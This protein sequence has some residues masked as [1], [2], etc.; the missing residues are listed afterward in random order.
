MSMSIVTN[1]NSLIAQENLRVNNEF[2]SRTIQRLTSGYRINSSGDDA[3]G[4]AVANKFR[5]D[6]AEL[7]QGIRNA[8]DGISALQ[9]IDGG[10]N[11]I[12]KMLDRLKTLATQS[13]SATFS[14]NRTTL[15][16]EYQALLT[17]INRQ[18][19]NV[20]L[21]VGSYGGR[22]NTNISVYVGGGGDTQAN[23]KVSIDLSGSSNRVD[24]VGLGLSG[25]SIAAG[26]ATEL[27]VSNDLSTGT[28]FLS[29]STS[30]DFTFRIAMKGMPATD[31][32]VTI[33]GDSDGISGNDVV[34]QFNNALASYG[35]SASLSGTTGKLQF[36]GATAFTLRVASQT[37]TNP[38]VSGAGNL[39]NESMYRLSGAATF[40]ALSGAN[41]ETVEFRVGSQSVSVTLNA[42][43][44]NTIQNALN[45]LNGAINGLGIYAVKNAAGT[46]VEF[47]SAANFQ[48]KLDA[49]ATEGVFAAMTDVT[50][51][52][53]APTTPSAGGGVTS[54]AE[55]AIARITTA[56]ANLGL[57]QGKVGTAQNKLQYSIQ[58]AQSQVASFS[59]AESRIRDADVAAEAANLTKAQVMQ[60][61][62]LAAMAQANSAPQS[63]LALLRG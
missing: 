53:D 2:Q 58:L 36:S 44:G 20:G 57:V 39:T 56:V 24:A 59:A 9:I 54:A 31:I 45:T 50:T 14:G 49:H 47:Q 18:A 17:E 33:T 32:T 28:T 40:V 48:Y 8:N 13:A 12:S 38:I 30:Q 35:I 6:V 10:L 1:V 62:S 42:T 37:G 55:A 41:T 34:T 23:S 7:Q 52:T 3:A 11:N 61:A 25:T 60:Q 19:E 46:G 21:G 5:S 15:N 43:N 26:G 27:S 29:G 63:V 4:L 16:N 51:W 22:Y